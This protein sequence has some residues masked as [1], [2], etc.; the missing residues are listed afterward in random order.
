MPQFTSLLSSSSSVQVD[1]KAPGTFIRYAM[2]MEGGLNILGGL[3]M[4]LKPEVLL[5]LMVSKPSHVTDISSSMMQW[6]GAITLGLTPQL[7][8]AIPNTRGAME[9]RRMAYYTLGAGE[10][11]LIPVFLWQALGPNAGSGLG[12]TPKALLLVTSN[13]LPPLLL[14][15][16]VLFVNPSLLGRYREGAKSE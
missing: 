13:L 11:A 3:S 5:G 2:A 6:L 16:Y 14:R 8:L 15:A 1:P 9:S 4:L 7:F 10:L 12:F